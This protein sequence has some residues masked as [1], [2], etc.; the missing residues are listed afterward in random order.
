MRPGILLG[1]FEGDGE[2]SFLALAAEMR[3]WAVIQ[4]KAEIIAM[5][6]DECRSKDP[7]TGP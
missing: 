2:R 6:A 5:R 4:Q 3:G 1:H 7:F